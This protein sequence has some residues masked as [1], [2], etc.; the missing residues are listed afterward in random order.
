M[1]KIIDAIL[2]LVCW[3]AITVSGTIFMLGGVKTAE[4]LT[5][6]VQEDMN[7]KSTV[8]TDH[9]TDTLPDGARDSYGIE[10]YDGIVSAAEAAS[11]ITV[12]ASKGTPVFING[13]DIS[14]KMVNGILLY[15]YLAEYDSGILLNG[16]GN[17]SRVLKNGAQYTRRYE[18]RG[19]ELYA[20]Y[21]WE[22]QP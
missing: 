18:I 2:F 1:E 22:N 5:D 20:V 6:M 13:V 17:L 11:E 4:K 7:R 16:N 10:H 14:K 9:T 12:Y 21:Y 15:T 19:E 8:Q 3:F